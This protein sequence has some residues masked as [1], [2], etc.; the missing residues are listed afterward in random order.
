MTTVK[1]KPIPLNGNGIKVFK[2][3]IKFEVYNS[4]TINHKTMKK[5]IL[6]YL[7]FQ[8]FSFSFAQFIKI[9]P[10]GITPAQGGGIDRMTTPDRT[11]PAFQNAQNTGKLVYDIDKGHLYLWNGT[12]WFQLLDTGLD[13]ISSVEK[14]ASNATNS[15]EFGF[16][17]AVKGNWA[18]IGAPGTNTNE[19]EAYIFK[20]T[21]DGWEEQKKLRE[22]LV[23]STVDAGARFGHSVDIDIITSGGAE[24]PVIVVG[25]INQD[26]TGKAF[27]F[28]YAD[29]CTLANCEVLDWRYEA[30]LAHPSPAI[31]DFFGVS[32]AISQ[33]RI[34]VGAPLDDPII[35]GS[36]Q[37]NLGS[38]CIY[39]ATSTGTQPNATF[40]WTIQGS[41]GGQASLFNSLN[42]ANG[43]SFGTTVDIDNDVVVV[44]SPNWSTN[45]GRV[46]MYKLISSAWTLIKSFTNAN[47][48]DVDAT[49]YIGRSVALSGLILVIGVP[50]ENATYDNVGAIQVV[51]NNTSAWS[52]ASAF[53]AS[54]VLCPYQVLN[55][56][57]GASVGIAGGY[58]IAGTPHLNA[59]TPTAITSLGLVA[60]FRTSDLGH[61][62]ITTPYRTIGREFGE[63]VAIDAAG[64]FVIGESIDSSTWPGKVHFGNASGY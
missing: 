24:Y 15:S 56:Q 26:L 60:A 20:R 19:G 11:A 45:N 46:D 34:I 53:T 58:I 18:V 36:A 43:D 1:S 5:I 39:Q 51:K 27:V 4:K 33:N 2:F 7:L 16:S 23:N 10:T 12:S 54:E 55:G 62:K 64:T 28:R 25:A 52:A 57:F 6:T 3:L 30:I 29:I 13:S 48:D 32:V 17:V 63:A 44:G 8:I 41:S 37:T 42:G 14:G 21:A 22:S 61:I 38:A 49:S 50:G 9:E 47:L 40:T 35:G 59:T 31:D